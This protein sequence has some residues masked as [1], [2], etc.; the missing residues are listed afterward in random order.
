[1]TETSSTFLPGRLVILAVGAVAGLLSGLL[2]VG[3]GIVLV[4]LLTGFLGFEQHRA[5]AHSLAAIVLIAISGA[6]TF[7]LAG[8]IDV[9]VGL[10]LGLGG[11]VGSN[12][13]AHLMNRLSAVALRG[14]FG[15]IMIATGVR[16]VWGDGLSGSV[17]DFETLT[18]IGV[19]VGIGLVAGV[20][21]GVAGIGGG[22]VMVPAMIY[23]L[24]LEQH[25]A[26]G[27]SLV[28]ILFTAVAGTRVNL[29]HGQV[30]LGGAA[31]IGIGGVISAFVGAR[32]ALGLSSATLARVF[33]VLVVFVGLRMVVRLVLDERMTSGRRDSDAPAGPADGRQEPR[34]IGEGERDG[35]L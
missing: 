27:T 24:G 31:L 29:R 13:G 10:S 20:A 16:M 7:T 21:S 35:H 8:E 34:D 23:L 9:V 17:G 30:D 25:V 6:T 14:V 4:P 26:E 2:G 12:A 1:V 18:T 3:G 11:V 28:A 32:F 33:G 15:L 19:A 22:V 5:H